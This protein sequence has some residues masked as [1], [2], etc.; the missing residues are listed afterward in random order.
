M[1]LLLSTTFVDLAA[2]VEDLLSDL[3]EFARFTEGKSSELVVLLLTALPLL[4]TALATGEVFSFGV[5][6]ELLFT[7]PE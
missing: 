4:E 7:F 3:V 6:A 1:D 5:E 2:V